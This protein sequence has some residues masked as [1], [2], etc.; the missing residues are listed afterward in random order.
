MQQSIGTESSL[1][2]FPIFEQAHTNYPIERLQWL[3]Q[4]PK[5]RFIFSSYITSS[6][7]AVLPVLSFQEKFGRK[8]GGTK[9][10]RK[11]VFIFPQLLLMRELIGLGKMSLSCRI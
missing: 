4:L 8:S 7:P 2:F 10:L 9:K 5:K 1:C 11:E 6:E 3:Q